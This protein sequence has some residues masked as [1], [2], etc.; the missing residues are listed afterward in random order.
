MVIAIAAGAA[1]SSPA[2]TRLIERKRR[3]RHYRWREMAVASWYN[4][5]AGGGNDKIVVALGSGGAGSSGT[6][7]SLGEAFGIAANRPS[8]SSDFGDNASK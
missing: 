3:G 8:P 4:R 6:G 7:E 5:L 1:V 2:L